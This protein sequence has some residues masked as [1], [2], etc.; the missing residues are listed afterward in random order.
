VSHPEELAVAKST[1]P[2]TFI[3]CL[4]K[5]F[6]DNRLWNTRTDEQV[7]LPSIPLSVVSTAAS[8]SIEQVDEQL[9]GSKLRRAILQKFKELF[10]YEMP[11]KERFNGQDSILL[12]HLGGIFSVPV[13][14]MTSIT[15]LEDLACL[16]EKRT[17]RTTDSTLE[18]EKPAEMTCS[19]PQVSAVS[20][21]KNGVRVAILGSALRL[22]GNINKED[23]LWNA[24]K[25]GKDCISKSQS[26]WSEKDLKYLKRC[27]A[28]V[29]C[30]FLSKECIETF[31]FQLFGISKEEASLMDP[32]HR[33]MIQMVWELLEN[34]GLLPELWR[35]KASVGVFLG[36][37]NSDYQT[38]LLATLDKKDGVNQ[39]MKDQAAVRTVATGVAPST[40][41]G[42]VSFIF[43][44][45]GPTFEVDTACSSSMSCLYLGHRALINGDCDYV[46]VGG[47]NLILNPKYT[48]CLQQAGILSPMGRCQAFTDRADGYVRSEGCCVLLL[49]REEDAIRQ[50]RSMLAVLR[51]VQVNQDGRTAQMMD[52][53]LDAQVR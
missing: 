26:R 14:E 4:A 34:T 2:P 19:L 40:L 39:L 6:L 47:V 24:V 44:F 27:G 42:R 21:Q 16:S 13:T 23:D 51:G 25:N 41:A 30:G 15:S 17:T 32:Q 3:N 28:P 29:E 18:R 7:I 38:E 31:D 49:Q 37:W 52:P 1:D 20:S 5:F 11:L 50:N 8:C 53:S 45:R 48:A 9:T 35:K 36:Q 10:H 33:L 43:D 22:P 12:T 46:I